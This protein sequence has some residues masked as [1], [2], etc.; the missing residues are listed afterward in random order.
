MRQKHDA[1]PNPQV[2]IWWVRR[3]LRLRDNPALDAARAVGRV[4]PVFILD[5][6]LQAA[7]R[8]A[9]RRMSFLLAG[10]HHLDADLRR[11]GSRLILRR[12]QPVQ[13]L[14]E[15]CAETGARW[16]FAERDYTPYAV[17]RDSQV[18][19]RLPL[20]LTPGLTV[21]PPDRV[22]RKD[23]KPFTVFTPFSRAW[24]SLPLPGPSDLIPA[25]E[26]L[27]TPEDIPGLPL[28]DA[29]EQDLCFP[30]GESEAL[31][32]LETFCAS[33]AGG[34]GR[35]ASDRNLPGVDG[36]SRL[37]PYLRFGMISARQAAVAALRAADAASS[38]EEREGAQTWLSQLIWRE[39]FMAV[40][41]AFPHARAQALRPELRHVRWTNDCST[42]EAWCRGETGFPMVDA[43][44]RQLTSCGWIHNR[45]RMVAAS[46]LVKQLLIDWR[47]GEDWFLRNLVDGDLAVNNGSWQW[48][49]GTGT[50]AAPYF[51]IFNPIVQSQQFDPDGDYIRRW[52]PELRPLPSST[53]HTPWRLSENE[54]R[55]LGVRIGKDYPHP[56]IDLATARQRALDAYSLSRLQHRSPLPTD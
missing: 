16:I 37:S 24:K 56:L 34:I 31:D 41:L 33:G 21:H 51:R 26:N 4:V 40:L 29:G 23:G 8:A 28:P 53:I 43:A 10:L 19:T 38:P 30:A 48:V 3:D 46:F 18:A 17:R 52:V 32:R 50:D 9:S 35:Y 45:P 15:L 11:R 20:H 54:Q 42:F 5:T 39:F 47:W 2:A 12:G 1:A 13:A 25:P 36:T 22:V 7:S 27:D 55:R 14:A 49:A 6:H 44:M